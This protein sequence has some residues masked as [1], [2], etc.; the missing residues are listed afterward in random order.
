MDYEK[1]LKR[2]WQARQSENYFLEIKLIK[3]WIQFGLPYLEC[4]AY[5]SNIVLF[6]VVDIFFD[7]YQANSYRNQYNYGTQ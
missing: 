1:T 5:G 3:N 6:Y 4:C 7:H 2:L